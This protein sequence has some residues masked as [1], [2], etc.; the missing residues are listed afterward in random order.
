MLE[1][2]FPANAPSLTSG[3]TLTLRTEPGTAQADL[4]STP[5]NTQGARDREP[6]LWMCVGTRP[7]IIKMA[8]VYR[9]IRKAGTPL[10]LLHTGQHDALAE[11]LYQALGI[12]P[13]M[14]ISLDR[15]DGS[16]AS[17]SA[18]LLRKL[19][20]VIE[21][22]RPAALLVHGDT[23]SAAMAALAGFY[24]HIP[25][26]HV[27]AGLRS[28]SLSDPFPEELNR[29]LIA[30]IARWHFAPTLA[31]VENLKA[32]GVCESG[33]HL[34]GNTVVDAAQQAI[35]RIEARQSRPAAL[36]DEIDPMRAHALAT[37]SVIR[38]RAA[39]RLM[40]VTA[41]RRENW[42]GP[43]QGIFR[44][45]AME[46]AA[47]D[48]LSVVWTLH[49]N[50]ALAASVRAL[51][52][53]L[54][55]ELGR[56]LHLA[57]PLGYMEMISLMRRAWLVLTDSGGLQEEACSLG[58]PVLVLR[59]HTERPEL[60][61]AGAGR[62]IGTQPLTVAAEIE[63]LWREPGLHQAM[64]AVRNPFGDGHAA[65]RIAQVMSVWYNGDRE[66]RGAS[67]RVATG[68]TGA[69]RA[70]RQRAGERPKPQGPALLSDALGPTR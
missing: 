52:A 5:E 9:A 51:H 26:A 28:H 8:P 47:H 30:R 64:Q 6:T 70:L 20:P 4:R 41:H 65:V 31:A 24:R 40:I 7:E 63:R 35:E 45:V 54:P 11:P 3:V 19:D 38:T 14:R 12:S 44:A 50:P 42:G 25:V 18:S 66:P 49:A 48:E 15:A 57:E 59:D 60:I 68:L 22:A 2:H 29:S 61:E 34:V 23:S 33:I 32:E 46:L 37:D 36:N 1:K 55:Q 62:L 27:E 58:V 67:A 16:L 39:A 53:G 69:A 21:Q 10:R 13:D 56:R 17:L 43:I